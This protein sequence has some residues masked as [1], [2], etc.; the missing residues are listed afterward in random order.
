LSHAESKKGKYLQQRF[1][2]KVALITG[3]GSGIGRAAAEAYSREGARVVVA[4]RAADSGEETVAIIRKRGGDAVF[5][6]T[7][8]SQ[9]EQV[10]NLVDKALE[11][12]GRVDCA[13]NNAGIAGNRSKTADYTEEIWDET[14]AVNLKGT[15]LCMKYEI[16]AMLQT[17]RGTIVN[18]SSVYGLLG[19]SRL[20][21]YGASKHGIIGLTKS[22]ALEYCRSGLRINAVCP[23]LI[24]TG[25]AERAIL[26]DAD[27]GEGLK[28]SLRER[29]VYR[30]K[31]LGARSVLASQQP[32]RRAGTPEEVADVVLWL[33]SDASSYVNGQA[34][35]VDG[36]MIIS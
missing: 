29:L 1:E 15:W 25:M 19:A 11:V 30:A 14:I 16:A 5:I 26:G 36:G 20:S 35:V 32:S 2:K 27:A 23:G 24:D 22:A 28:F 10:Q 18:N 34:L 3:A 7:D 4:D 8:V 33:S 12:F 6:Q 9:L 13:F 17:G 31:S 21:A